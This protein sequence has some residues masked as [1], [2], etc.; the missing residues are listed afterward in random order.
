LF[1][2]LL[3]F[4]KRGAL[5][6]RGDLERAFDRGHARCIAPASLAARSLA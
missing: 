4:L 2:A 3:E 1:Q 5:A 6:G